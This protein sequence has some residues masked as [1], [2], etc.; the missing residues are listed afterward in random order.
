MKKLKCTNMR[1]ELIIGKRKGMPIGLLITPSLPIYFF[2]FT[3]K[4]YFDQE[5]E[6][7]QSVRNCTVTR[8]CGNESN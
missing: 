5:R 4:G 6:Y 8:D 1:E 2:T 3:L 7:A